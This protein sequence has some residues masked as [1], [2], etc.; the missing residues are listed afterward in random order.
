M[1]A[2][3]SPAASAHWG[4]GR[5]AR[6]LR[7]SARSNRTAAPSSGVIPADLNHGQGCDDLR[8]ASPAHARPHHSLTRR[9][10]QLCSARDQ[11][12]CSMQGSQPPRARGWKA[13]NFHADEGRLGSGP[14][15]AESSLGDHPGRTCPRA[16][17]HRTH[18]P[19]QTH[20]ALAGRLVAMR[21]DDLNSSL[22]H[23]MMLH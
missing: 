17:P 8:P 16:V 19:N 12:Y 21:R 1:R 15:V 20:F 6:V 7:G 4:S 14:T 9:S 2:I 18:A 22:T 3:F 10:G 23:P 13:P 5:T 11:N